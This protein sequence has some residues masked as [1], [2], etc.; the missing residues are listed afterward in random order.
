MKF[1][2]ITNISTGTV[3]GISRYIENLRHT[4]GIKEEDVF[5]ISDLSADTVQYINTNF[6]FVSVQTGLLQVENGESMRLQ[7]L[8]KIKLK[9]IA[10]IHSVPDEEVRLL[11]EC[12]E[13]YFPTGKYHSGVVYGKR[14]E[15]FFLTLMDALIFSTYRDKEIFSSFYNLQIP[16]SIII[17]SVEYIL[18][19]IENTQINKNGN[20]GYLG[21]IDYRKGLLCSLNSMHFLNRYKL[22]VYGQLVRSLSHN[23]VILEHFLKK[24]SNIEYNG[25][26][27]NKKHY[28]RDT[29]IF[30]GNSLYE[31]FG[32]SHIENLVNNVIP[33][34]G[35]DTG[36]Q[37]IFGKE[38]PFVVGDSVPELVNTVNK[39]ST[40]NV[41][42]LQ[43]VLNHTI[44]RIQDLT[45]LTFKENYSNFCK[46]IIYSKE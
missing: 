21:R 3:N 27:I 44:T 45:D 40:I 2:I 26:L 30:L 11:D 1:C 35:K 34:I 41:E 12:M 8:K 38:Y 37:E 23:K 33:I 31:P 14:Y 4:F 32:Y 7:I 9:K 28:F 16:S 39:I 24:H 19:N 42:E 25:V 46:Q 22:K 10:T 18:K 13:N 29:F 15:K 36:T 6:D 5:H 20:L 17:P 43:D